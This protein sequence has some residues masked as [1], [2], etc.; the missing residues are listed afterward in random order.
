MAKDRMGVLELLRKKARDADL[1]FQR[2]GIRILIQAVMEAEVATKTEAS[3]GEPSPER[4]TYRDAYRVR[5]LGHADGHPGSAGPEG[6]GGQL[7]PLS[8]RTP[9]AKRTIPVRRRAAGLCGG[10]L[11]PPRRGHRTSV[12]C[13]GISKSQVSASRRLLLHRPAVLGCPDVQ[14]T[15]HV[16]HSRLLVGWQLLLLLVPIPPS[17]FPLLVLDKSAQS[18]QADDSGSNT[19]SG[20]T[21]SQL[22]Q[23]S[24]CWYS[25][26]DF[27][28]LHVTIART[29]ANL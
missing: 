16:V 6:A 14:P 3:F 4:D 27:S 5:P 29:V 17:L 2:E 26:S 28:R 25:G 7:L 13:E 21:T 1:E 22:S 23:R 15:F 10:R 9:P 11:H 8:A 19:S 18:R 12:G 20:T 24:P